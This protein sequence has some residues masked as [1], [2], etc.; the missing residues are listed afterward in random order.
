V[1]LR[2]VNYI[3]CCHAGLCLRTLNL[4]QEIHSSQIRST[5]ADER[6]QQTMI[7]VLHAQAAHIVESFVNASFN[8]RFLMLLPAMLPWKEA[9]Y[10][11]IFS[12]KLERAARLLLRLLLALASAALL[13]GFGLGLENDCSDPTVPQILP[14]VLLCCLCGRLL[15][16][17]LALLARRSLWPLRWALLA[18]GLLGSTSLL[19]LFLANA[20]DADGLWWLICF[21]GVL[22]L[23]LV[24]FPVL[25]AMVLTL[26][27][28]CTIRA[29]AA[30]H[31]RHQVLS[32]KG[33]KDAVQVTQ[34]TIRR[35]ESEA[36]MAP[37]LIRSISKEDSKVLSVLPGQAS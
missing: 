3:R 29:D 2:C 31:L 33:S 16:L 10:F 15:L 27:A 14:W 9:L 20:R 17:P 8:V 26:L 30:E 6:E 18:P 13:R 28:T 4:V 34:V 19:V 7:T 22:L 36:K 37:C 5:W 23:D 12:S 25:K 24:L 21:C 35:E 11:S 1:A 32:L